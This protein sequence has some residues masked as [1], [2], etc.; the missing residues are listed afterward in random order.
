M[1]AKVFKNTPPYTE[2]CVL[3]VF[4][5]NINLAHFVVSIFFR[6][7]SSQWRQVAIIMFFMFI[8]LVKMY[9]PKQCVLGK[10]IKYQSAST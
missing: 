5:L 2:I 3:Y 8:K 9:R 10:Y 1:F 6:I 7:Q 4:T